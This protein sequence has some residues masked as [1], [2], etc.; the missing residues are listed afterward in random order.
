MRILGL[1]LGKRHTG[2]AFVDT[3]PGFVMALDTI[4]HKRTE[5]LIEILVRIIK[6]KNIDALAIGLPRLLDGS[7]GEQADYVRCIAE[8]ISTAVHLPIQFIDE[9]Y[10]S[11]GTTKENA[12]AKAA[13]SI[14]ETA[15]SQSR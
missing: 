15:M 14:V 1:D 2:V 9:R 12:D 10:S 7:E 13:C 6:E 8:E 11:Y 3:V 4:K 5:E